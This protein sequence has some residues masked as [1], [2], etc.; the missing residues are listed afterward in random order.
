MNIPFSA[1]S[2]QQ[3][4]A[5]PLPQ[6]VALSLDRLS[7]TDDVRYVAV[8]PDVHLSHDVCTGT[9]LAT[10]RL[11][12]PHAVGSDIGCGMAALCFRCDASLLAD[13]RSA[14]RL[15]AGLYKTVPAIRHARRTLREKLPDHLSEKPLSSST[16]E[17]LKTRDG[18]V[19]FAT[20]GRGN[21]FL[22][23]QADDED[24]LWIMIHSG[25]RA[26]GQAIHRH[27]LEEARPANTG[28]PFLE[29]SSEPGAAY[30]ADVE[31]A[32]QY[33]DANRAAMAEAVALLMEELF[34]I[35][36]D[37][38]SLIRCNHN[39]VRR[40]THGTE[41]LWTHR[42]GAISAREGEPGIIPGSMGTA[43]FH[44]T[45]RGCAAA[46][47]S[48][49]HGAGRLLSRS[50]ALRSISGR[51]LERQMRHIW[52][53]HRLV[54][55]LRDEAPSAYKDIHAV[56]RA[57]CDLTRIVRKLRPILSYKGA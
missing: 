16:L 1:A 51:E 8:M 9:A 35:D 6:D 10:S 42:K 38:E 2:M 13:E 17:K 7:R 43:S 40:E 56:M 39:H 44:V 4:L 41:L 11:I 48:S 29:A 28:L 36:A 50:E 45:G 20:L 49:S 37:W 54:A 12:Y 22:E 52:F 5:G 25:S 32:C 53:D 19:E 55:K 57:Q 47:C 46:L 15:L 33:A 23:F 27:H 24:Q 31:W 3:W 14:A 18:R 26:L 21:H 34:G 30:L